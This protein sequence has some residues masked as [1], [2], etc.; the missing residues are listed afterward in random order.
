[1]IFQKGLESVFEIASDGAVLISGFDWFQTVTPRYEKLRCP[2]DVL[3]RGISRSVSVLRRT[4]F[5]QSDSL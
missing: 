3:Y 1:M 4:R 2:L 5:V